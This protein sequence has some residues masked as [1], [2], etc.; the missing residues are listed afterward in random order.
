MPRLP[1]LS[2]RLAEIALAQ[3]DSDRRAAA[4]NRDRLLSGILGGAQAAT[5]LGLGI[6]SQ[7]QDAADRRERARAAL[8]QEKLQGEGISIDRLREDR[9]SKTAE[10]LRDYYG[11]LAGASR[12]AA[13][14]DKDE[15]DAAER[16]RRFQ[17]MMASVREARAAS[18]SM[19]EQGFRTSSL[20]VDRDRAQVAREQLDELIRGNKVR[21]G[22]EAEAFATE[23][24][25]R[26]YQLLIAKAQ[27]GLANER[28]LAEIEALRAQAADRN[29]SAGSGDPAYDEYLR[30][31]LKA[32]MEGR[33]EDVNNDS[34]RTGEAPASKEEFNA[35]ANR[36]AAYSALIQ[37]LDETRGFSPALATVLSDS[38]P[39]L[40]A[41]QRFS[42]VEG[43]I[44]K[45]TPEQLAS[46]ALLAY[47]SGAEAGLEDPRF[48]NAL[49]AVRPYY[50]PE[51]REAIDMTPLELEQRRRFGVDPNVE[52][53]ARRLQNT[54][55]FA[56]LQGGP[57]VA[58]AESLDRL[59]SSLLERGALTEQGAEVVRKRL[60]SLA[61]EQNPGLGDAP[62]IEGPA[63]DDPILLQRLLLG[64]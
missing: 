20:E 47:A 61:A 42:A 57:S 60:R 62:A 35:I 50:A 28:E 9:E 17:R 46:A 10:S 26:R 58:N 43:A 40:P 44:G 24:Q 39:D 18:D 25:I 13:E 2:S 1:G 54:T 48:L 53:N 38:R 14:L 29:A 52:V 5:G 16:E 49:R 37:A 3:R 32:E 15:F 34:L 59:L 51:N 19:S 30:K 41:D 22:R 12:S 21:E 7:V 36:S 45:M 56:A 6:A 64:Q 11:A 8:A 27:A 63:P 55:P 23:Q 33:I 4:A 31:K